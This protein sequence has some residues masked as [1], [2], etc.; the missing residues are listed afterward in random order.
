MITAR[1]YAAQA[2][3]DFRKASKAFMRAGEIER[4]EMLSRIANSIKTSIHFAI[5]DGGKVFGDGFKGIRNKELHL[6]F[7]KITVEFFYNRNS[8]DI[9]GIEDVISSKY[10][11]IAEEFDEYITIMTAQYIDRIRKWGAQSIYIKIPIKWDSKLGETADGK[12]GFECTS[13]PLIDTDLRGDEYDH[14]AFLASTTATCVMELVEALTC[15]NISTEPL[16]RIDQSK[17]A[18]RIKDGKLPLYETKILTVDISYSKDSKYNG[19]TH[20]DRASVR[21]HLRRG[22]IRRHPTAGNIWV[23]ACVVGHSELGVI[24]KQYAVM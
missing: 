13:H 21:Q 6:P 12:P 20:N 14:A 10:V 23:N 17:N 8:E 18:R 22:H 2:E 1:N 4:A 5:P 3:Y 11:L 15:K 9:A 19:I 7:K 24:D 16:E